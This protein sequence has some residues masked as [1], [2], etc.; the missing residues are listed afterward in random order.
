M[1]LWGQ[2]T[3]S[4][5]R[6]QRAMGAYRPDLYRDALL[7]AAP[8]LQL[9]SSRPHAVGQFFDDRQFDPARLDSYLASFTVAGLHQ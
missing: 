9:P 6:L 4:A 5:V 2:T 8:E 3:P 7:A 1:V